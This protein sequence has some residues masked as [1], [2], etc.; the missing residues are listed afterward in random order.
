MADSR[1]RRK[2]S[3]DAKRSGKP[4]G[5]SGGGQPR[6]SASGA[7]SAGGRRSDTSGQPRPG[8]S[9]SRDRRPP[10]ED[11]AD[12]PT[13]SSE[14]ERKDE[15]PRYRIERVPD[16]AKSSKK[17]SSS[18]KRRRA[19]VDVSGVDFGSVAGSTRAKLTGRLEDAAKAFAGDRFGDAERLLLSI[20]KL[21]PGVPEVLE[22]LG[23][24]RYRQG[25][26]R[27]AAADLRKFHAVTGSVEQHPVLADCARAM[28]EW[29]E[30]ERL[31]KELGSESPEP[32]LIEEG[33]IVMA[34]S[35]ADQGRLTDAIRTLEKAP[36]AKGRPSV[37]H[38]RRWYALGDLYERV[39]DRAHARRLFGQIVNADST[40]GDAAERLAAL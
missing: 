18:S 15:T 40:F 9:P 30:V 36:S 25:K 2:P 16:E 17:R 31:W 14:F 24:S 32:A 22:L 23:L 21:A 28:E 38:M 26:W 10:S 29:N 35:L 12:R 7:R 20:D 37:H 6:R 13:P 11:R 33:R 5:R 19:A 27:K 4:G 8:G 3:S 1:P 39:G 34:G